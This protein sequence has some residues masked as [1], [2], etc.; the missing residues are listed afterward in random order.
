MLCIAYI[1][2]LKPFSG[3][4][5]MWTDVIDCLSCLTGIHCMVMPRHLEPCG[6]MLSG[7]I[8]LNTCE[9]LNWCQ[10]MKN[11]HLCGFMLSGTLFWIYMWNIKPFQLYCHVLL[12]YIAWWCQDMEPSSMIPF[13]LQKLLPPASKTFFRVAL[14]CCL[15][16][17]CLTLH[18]S[19]LFRNQIPTTNNTWTPFPNCS[20]NVAFWYFSYNFCCHVKFAKVSIVWP[21]LY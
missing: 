2:K 17:H 14:F 5:C 9:T 3:T 7:Y 12:A 19:D 8:V 18:I 20:P 16:L 6:F 1:W 11:H 21:C 10:D 15:M 13:L 4:Y